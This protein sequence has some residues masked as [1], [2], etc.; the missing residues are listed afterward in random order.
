MISLTSV[1]RYSMHAEIRQTRKEAD[2]K[3]E[4]TQV[5][6]NSCDG[7]LVNIKG[8]KLTSTCAK[9]HDHHYSLAKDAKV[10]CD[11][12]DSSL[13]DLKVGSTIR[14]TMSKDDKSKIMAIDCG[15]H[16]PSISNA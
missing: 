5:A 4:K 10:S 14:M 7:K 2:M 3:T 1:M 13:A 11:G 6:A 12:K 16:I 8:D 15:K 9:G